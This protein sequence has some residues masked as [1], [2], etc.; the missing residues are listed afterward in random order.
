MVLEVHGLFLQIELI[1]V[2]WLFP[3]NIGDTIYVS[4]NIPTKLNGYVYNVTLTLTVK[5]TGANIIVPAGTFICAVYELDAWNVTTNKLWF[6]EFIHAS[7]TSGIIQREY[8]DFDS[9]NWVAFNIQRKEATSKSA[10]KY[11][12]QKHFLPLVRE[13]F[14]IWL[15]YHI[16]IIFRTTLSYT[17]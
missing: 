5:Q 4:G 14:R 1:S 12:S 2:S 3:G 8:D 17:N 16:L 9:S 7:G 11:S 10:I 15:C 6:K 13:G